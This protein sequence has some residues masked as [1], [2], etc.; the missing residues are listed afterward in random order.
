[1]NKTI[2]LLSLLLSTCL[3]LSAT[4]ILAG[5]EIP[6]EKESSNSTSVSS[7]S[8][9]TTVAQTEEVLPE[10]EKK[11]YNDEFYLHI[12]P[13]VN[14]TKYY[15][16]EESENDILSDAIYSRQEKVRQ[17]IGVDVVGFATGNYSQYLEPFK[18]AV[19]NKDGS[20]DTL[21]SHVC[22]DIDG[23]IGENY[24]VELST[25]PGIDL[26]ADYW[27]YEFM[28]SISIADRIYL[29]FSDFNILYTHVVA[30]NKTLLEKYDDGF[31][32]SI[33]SMVD[34]YRWTLDKMLSLSKMAYIDKTND[35]KTHD[36]QFGITGYQHISFVGFL[37][38]SNI[39][40]VE[41]NEKGDYVVTVYNDANREKTAALVD[42]LRDLVLSD[43][44]W[45]WDDYNKSTKPGVGLVTNR[46]LF[47]LSTTYA[48]PGY[49]EHDVKFGV[50]PYPL[51]DENQKDA[52]YRSLQWGGYITVP[53][54][55]RNIELVGDTLELL[56][57]YS[58]EVTDAF[59]Q[60]LLGKQVAD[61][62]DDKR[63][64]DI[65]WDSVC[66]DFGQTYYS[67][68]KSTRLLYIVPELTY[69]SS[70][71]NIA[72]FMAKVDKMANKSFRQFY[73]KVSKMQNQ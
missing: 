33:Y 18:T 6:E 24:V 5:C 12:L 44:G 57:F 65:V 71:Q 42:K 63:M 45:F 62:P 39:N 10:V 41:Q 50:L 67:V 46:T 55:V 37:H 59:Y 8:E 47:N 27:N 4:A 19:K 28:E 36:D 26:E 32:E 9:E 53:S 2:R 35:G 22:N 52:G 56:S 34:N 13:D 29:G 17:H 64:L 49:T 61:S 16:V 72:S 25:V 54:Y 23:L 60:K 7:G 58:D 66:S 69:E 48:L 1:M 11:N 21:I 30:F 20:V 14:P 3:T 70:N 43:Y 40:L 15:W 51:W 73:N 38:A 68:V 31:D